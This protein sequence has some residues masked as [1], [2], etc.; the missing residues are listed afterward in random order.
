MKE[1]TLDLIR[2]SMDVGTHYIKECIN[3]KLE[4]QS[5]KL[6]DIRDIFLLTISKT[7]YQN[8]VIKKWNKLWKEKLEKTITSEEAIALQKS[9]PP[10]MLDYKK[11]IIIR[12]NEIED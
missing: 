12:I 4:L 3:E 6:E 9:H 5:A 8:E 11:N 10:D 7:P 1:E 2:K